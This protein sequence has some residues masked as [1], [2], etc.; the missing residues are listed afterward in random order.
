VRAFFA[1]DVP[2]ELRRRLADLVESLRGSFAGASFVRTE[3]V[4]LTLRFLGQTSDEQIARLTAWLSPVARAQGPIHAAVSGLG[5]F[6]DR[7]RPAVLWLGVFADRSLARLQASCEAA[8][9]G[10]G[11]PPEGRPF[12]PHL[13]LARFRDHAPRPP[14]PT[15]DLGRTLFT[16]LT[17]FKSELRPTGSVYSAL[18][19]FRL[20]P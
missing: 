9:V 4:H 5:L 20:G 6:P 3:G 1:L 7:G 2:P 18:E 14:L 16:S 8:A 12:R 13:T 19:R 15:A 11:F 17:L 10:A